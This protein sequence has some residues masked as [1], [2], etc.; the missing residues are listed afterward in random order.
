MTVPSVLLLVAMSV[1]A[2][3]LALAAL[4]PAPALRLPEESRLL[5]VAGGDQAM[6]KPG[7]DR[8]RLLATI[9][10]LSGAVHVS[11]LFVPTQQS[12]ST[13]V[14]TKQRSPS[15]RSFLRCP[16]DPQRPPPMPPRH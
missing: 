11:L 16:T 2:L 12:S 5:S 1:L 15:R 10:F 7:G 8:S 3:A 4:L 14:V 13:A 9:L 6:Q